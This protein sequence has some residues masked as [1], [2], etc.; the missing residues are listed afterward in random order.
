MTSDVLLLSRYFPLGASSRVRSYQYL[1]ALRAAGVSVTVCPLFGDAYVEMRHREGGLAFGE[2]AKAYAGRVAA[3]LRKNAHAA[4]WVE[5]EVFPWLPFALE[6]AM[7]AGPQPIV[8][9]YDDAIFHRYDR[10]PNAIVRRFLGAKIDRIMRAATV[11]VTGNDYLADRARRA[12]AARVEIIP[13]VIDLHRYRQKAHVESGRFTIGWIGS[14]STTPYLRQIEPVLH[15]VADIPGLSVLNIGGNAW[16]PAGLTVENVE[17][18]EAGEVAQMLRA[19]VGIMPLPDDP[20]TRGKCGYKLIQYMG[21]GLP[22]VASPVSANV[23]I[24]DD[25]RTGFLASS[26]EEWGTALRALAASPELRARMGEAGHARVE[27]H[28]ALAVTAPR[29]TQL[30]DDL[31][32]GRRARDAS[33]VDAW[34]NASAPAAPAAPG[35]VWVPIGVDIAAFVATLRGRFFA[36][37]WQGIAN[38]LL[39]IAVL[40]AG[41]YVARK[42]GAEA[43]ARYSLAAVTVLVAG[44]LPGTVLTTVGSKFVPELSAGRPDRLG[45]GFAPLLLLTVALSAAIGIALLALAPLLSNMFDHLYGLKASLTGMLQLAALASAAV[46]LQGGANGMLVGCARFNHAALVNLAAV[47]LFVVLLLPLNNAFGA[48]GTL[49][50]LAALYGGAAAL[51]LWANR[52]LIVRDVRDVSRRVLSR[53][54]RSMAAFFVP[55]LLAAG[56]VAPVVWLT[57]TFFARGDAPLHDIAR[58]NASFSWFSVVTFVP[59]VLAQVEFVRMSQ[60]KAR[61]DTAGLGRAYLMFILQNAAVMLPIAVIGSLAAGPLMNLFQ[62]DD[63]DGRL[64][65]RLMLAAAFMSSLGNPAGLLLAVIDRIW[66]ASLLNAAWAVVALIAAWLLRS[67]G[68][69]GVG[70]AFAAA[71]TLHFIVAGTLAWRM[72]ARHGGARR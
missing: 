48:A 67:H 51:A 60:A 9:D 7:Y 8:A 40:F 58:L 30:W 68:A 47:A 52:R 28:F 41:F 50:A 22:V 20:W 15:Q 37:A 35:I 65:L 64:S 49:V 5:L 63:A 12:G 53:H 18:S 6:R 71:Y 13:S 70:A 62:V 43:Y 4:L 39:R 56:M 1:E 54:A 72:V 16:T 45:R 14:P 3:C 21:C 59:A 24:V 17:W 26:A 32:R 10:H 69:P 57:N 36:A 55:T 31:L 11:V 66:V 34:D 46:V 27:A 23:H 61:N 42:F 29:I 33:S 19:D 25:R 2:L 38:G 44:N